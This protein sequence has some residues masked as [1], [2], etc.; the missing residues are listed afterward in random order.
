MELTSKVRSVLVSG[1]C[2][3]RRPKIATLSA[4]ACSGVTPGFSR[5]NA[6]NLDLARSAR[7]SSDSAR[8]VHKLATPISMN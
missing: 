5:P 4:P 7:S 2:F 6:D 1:N 3:S 8:G